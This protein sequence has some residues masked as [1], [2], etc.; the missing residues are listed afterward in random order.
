MS[1]GQLWLQGAQL[2]GAQLNGAQLNGAQLNGRPKVPFA[3]KTR[4][5]LLSAAGRGRRRGPPLG[6][7][8]P[9]ARESSGRSGP[10]APSRRRR[11]LRAPPPCPP[12]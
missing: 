6:V 11:R 12:G 4:C 1:G 2:Q 10:G 3:S 7:V 8:P 5:G 9:E